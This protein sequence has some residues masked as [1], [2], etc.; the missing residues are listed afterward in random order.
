M[1]L[2]ESDVELVQALREDGRASFESLA[3]RVGLTRKVVRGRVHRLFDEGVLRVV[4]TV[5][6]EY[7]DIHAIAH[8]SLTVVGAR[9]EEVAHRLAERPET[10]FVS[11]VSGNANVVAEI[12]TLDLRSLADIV[13]QVATGP[14]V[15]GV[16]S[17][18]YADVLK[19]PHLPPPG[20][21]DGSVAPLD[22]LDHTLIR[23]LRQDGRA[24]YSDL[25]GQVGLSAAATRARVR[26]LLM[27]GVIRI[28]AL[29]NPTTLGRSFMTGF[30]LD[31]AGPATATLAALGELGTVDFL[32]RTLGHADAIGT[33]VTATAEDTITALDEIAALP[34]VREVTS[35]THLRLLQERYA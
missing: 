34:G 26:H 12:R 11:I 14:G 4:A 6:P 16:E 25:A 10:V 2:Q 29:V 7:D 31:L 30:A 21:A 5:A 15:V 19:E 20:A 32:A 24:S 22:E 35:W 27:T 33:L 3:A 18:V 8:L 23:L 17:L 13:N 28:V 9:R 1:R